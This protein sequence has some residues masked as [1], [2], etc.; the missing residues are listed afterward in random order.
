MTRRH[1]RVQ[2]QWTLAHRENGEDTGLN[3]RR[4]TGQE[5]KAG[6]TRERMAGQVPARTIGHQSPVLTRPIVLIGMM[7]AGKTAVGT[8]IAR[9]LQVPF[10]DSDEEL[11]RAAQ[12]SV[13]EIFERDGEAFF[14]ARESEVL[15]RLM[16]GPAA[17]IS[18]GGGAFMSEAN[19]AVIAAR[20]VS[21]WLQADLDLLWLRVRQNAAR[22]L[23]RTNDPKRTLADLLAVREPVYGLA[24][25]S[26][27]AEQGIGID[28]MAQKVIAQ[29]RDV[30]NLFSE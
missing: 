14:R 17:V 8:Q 16:A 12:R 19:R 5:T 1:Q 26:V 25:V 21:V 10:V 30:P 24:Q 6:L 28:A 9:L 2:T 4:G 15:A 23:L 18:T 13:A 3:E 20:G 22:P 7:G 27:A 29:L 11:V